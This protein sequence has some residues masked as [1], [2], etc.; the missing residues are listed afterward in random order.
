MSEPS[1]ITIK[2][3]KEMVLVSL[4]CA[5]IDDEL[6]NAAQAEVAAAADK[7]GRLPVLLE[8]SKVEILP[9][10]SIGVLV[11]LWQRLNAEKR[12]FMLAGLQPQVRE[13]LTVCRLDKLFLNF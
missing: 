8:M 10:R 3:H 7:A 6:A 13:T 11:A 12:R 4:E 9:S 2:P 1:G 5:A